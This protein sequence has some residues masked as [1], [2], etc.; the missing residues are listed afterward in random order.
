M[1][2]FALWMVAFAVL[3]GSA[4]YAQNLTGTWQ[5]T[6][7]EGSNQSARTVVKIAKADGGELSGGL[8]RIDEGVG[9]IP[10]SMITFEGKT[11][12]F[13]VDRMGVTYAGKLSADGASIAGVWTHGSTTHSL[14]LV[15]ATQETAW[16]LP[17][18]PT[19][20]R[21]MPAD[22]EPG[23]LVVTIKPSA[24]DR[25]GHNLDF[26]GRRFKITRF[27]VNDMIAFAY[28]FHSREIVGAP[29]WFSTDAFDVDGVPDVEGDPNI[30]QLKIMVQKLL[31]ERFRLVFHRDQ[32]ELA[33]YA[34]TVGKGGPKLAHS[35]VGPNDE[36]G[37]SFREKRGLLAVRNLTM[38]EFAIEMQANVMDKPVVDQTGL[39][40]RYDF[41]LD[42]TPDDSQFLQ[43]RAASPTTPL[44]ADD[45]NALPGLST[46]MQEQLG[47]KLEATKAK[48]DVI[49]ID[50]VEK[51]SPN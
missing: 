4:L 17:E 43:Q 21:E 30:K 48:T 5:G 25:T 6:M 38:L 26:E 40:E 12:K 1:R 3:G 46:A 42:W 32:R 50:H 45:P 37:F 35:T 13:T 49:V 27:T 11:V 16:E 31:T 41:N 24:P 34:I 19:A 44:P 33:V 47:L 29:A 39:N 51:P 28:G 22:A 8:Y 20:P 2:K 36:Y 18:P 9:P 23:F 15:R 10:V 14:I 7:Q